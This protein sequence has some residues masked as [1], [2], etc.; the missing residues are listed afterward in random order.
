MET[1]THAPLVIERSYDAPIHKVWQAL[2]DKEQMK[3]WYFDIADF[4]PIVGKEFTFMAGCDGEHEHLH[5][6]KITR[7]VPNQVIAYTWTYPGQDGH[8]EVSFELFPDNGKTK[9]V[10]THTGLETFVQ[11]GDFDKKNFNEGWTYFVDALDKF[12]RE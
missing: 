8:S 12:L 9:L 1:V 10:L 4:E 11:G 3:Q 6:C 7:L 5:A 2:T